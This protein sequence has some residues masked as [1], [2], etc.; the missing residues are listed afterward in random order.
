LAGLFQAT[1]AVDAEGLAHAVI[2]FRDA[3]NEALL[4]GAEDADYRAAEL[5]QGAK[6]RPFERKDELLQE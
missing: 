5:A 1:G 3:D 2:D 4:R 6:D